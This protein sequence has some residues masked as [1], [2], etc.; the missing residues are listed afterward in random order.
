M[1]SPNCPP[2][3][4]ESFWTSPGSSLFLGG[5][6]P[7]L[8]RG[9]GSTEARRPPGCLV[10]TQRRPL[11]GPGGV[12]RWGCWTWARRWLCLNGPISRAT[13][14]SLAHPKI[15]RSL[16][17]RQ[18]ASNRLRVRPVLPQ[19]HIVIGLSPQPTTACAWGQIRSERSADRRCSQYRRTLS[20]SWNR[21]P[22][23]R[24]TTPSFI[25]S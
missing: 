4:P 2:D 5:V 7:R 18:S 3:N 10:L 14:A 6:H 20:A 15:G 21:R 23:P 1:R 12:V 16:A 11:V 24:S 9:N 22:E 17:L 13:Q 19:F 8:D 25:R